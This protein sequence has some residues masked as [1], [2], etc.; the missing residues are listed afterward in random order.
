MVGGKVFDAAGKEVGDVRSSAVSPARGPI[1]IAMIRREVE[2]GSSVSVET[3]TGTLPAKVE[4]IA[5]R[6]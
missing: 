6:S 1:A 2:P 3:P 5:L 4:A